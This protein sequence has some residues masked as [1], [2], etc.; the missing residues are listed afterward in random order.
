MNRPHDLLEW[1]C[2][3]PEKGNFAF[4]YYDR[5]AWNQ[6]DTLHLAL[7]MP[8]QIRLPEVDETA[9]LGYIKDKK[10]V[11]LTETKAWCHQQGCMSVFLN[12]S[13]IIY[14]DVDNST[15]KVISKVYNLDTHEIKPWGDMIYTISLDCTKVAT[16]DIGRIPRRG[17]SYASS[18]LPETALPVNPANEGLF[19]VDVATK[20]KRL[21]LSY[22]QCIDMHPYPW[23][24]E[25]QMFWMNH[26]IFNCDGSK[27]LVL[28]RHT[29][30]TSER[31]GAWWRT[32]MFT[33][34]VDGGNVKC[35][36][37]DVFWK[38]GGITHQIWGSKPNDVLVDAN[39]TH[40]GNHQV[41]V[42]DRTFPDSPAQLVS[43]GANRGAHL[44]YSPDGKWIAGDSYPNDGKQ[45]LTLT[46]VETGECKIIGVFN[47]NT[48]NV[49][50]DMRCDLHPRWNHAGDYLTVDTIHKGPRKIYGLSMKKVFESYS[51]LI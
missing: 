9:E 24:K 23:D 7:K 39:W 49:V 42:D 5:F 17:Y 30:N 34:D 18:P 38:N 25:G 2:L 4:G 10:F 50:G 27:I 44:L 35:V 11:K 12:D 16:L 1:E 40:T 33:L 22:Q 13:E 19:I 32:H 20:E 21:I 31:S 15:G 45:T 6:S 3:V 48:P 43:K 8:Q 46:K 47:H 14:N 37:P 26:A 28:F 41:I 36:L 29:L 51:T